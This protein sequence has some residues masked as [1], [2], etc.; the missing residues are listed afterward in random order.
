MFDFSHA[1]KDPDNGLGTDRLSRHLDI[2]FKTYQ[3]YISCL[4]KKKRQIDEESFD[5][6]AAWAIGLCVR[7]LHRE[8][9]GQVGDISPISTAFSL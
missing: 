7:S 9:G 3:L 1:Y 4:L 8:E 6:D 5:T 2:F